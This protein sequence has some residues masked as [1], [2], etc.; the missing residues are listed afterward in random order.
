MSRTTDITVRAE[1]EQTLGDLIRSYAELQYQL[2]ADAVYRQQLTLAEELEAAVVGKHAVGEAT[3][4]E[5]DRTR[6][7]L[8][9]AQANLATQRTS[10]PLALETLQVIAGEVGH[11]QRVC[12]FPSSPDTGEE[13]AL[14]TATRLALREQQLGLKRLDLSSAWLGWLPSAAIVG[15]LSWSGMGEDTATQASGFTTY[16]SYYVGAQIS[17]TLGS[18]FALEMVRANFRQDSLLT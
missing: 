18:G 14:D 5:L 3:P 11:E 1:E 7:D 9:K 16:D 10:L 4:I 15:G 13:L 2:G 17:M 12:P 6:L 8:E